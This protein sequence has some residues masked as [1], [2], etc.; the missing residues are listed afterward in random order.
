MPSGGLIV[1]QTSTVYVNSKRMSRII[2]EDDG[3]GISA[4]DINAIFTPFYSTKSGHDNQLSLGLGL[5]ITYRIIE[6]FEGTMTATNIS[7]SGCRFTIDL[8]F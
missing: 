3:P 2:F 1:I 5:S 6:S 7:P 4:D 8:P